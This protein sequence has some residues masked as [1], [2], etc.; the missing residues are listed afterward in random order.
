M[1]IFI[2]TRRLTTKTSPL[3]E[4]SRTKKPHPSIALLTRVIEVLLRLGSFSIHVRGRIRAFRFTH[5][6][7]KKKKRKKRRTKIILS[8]EII[9][10]Q[11]PLRETSR[12]PFPSSHC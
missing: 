7:K 4:L 2:Y 3:V 5:T 6:R 8:I 1:Y 9:L 12:P 11:C 10:L